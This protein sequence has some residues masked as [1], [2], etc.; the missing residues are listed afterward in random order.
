[1]HA[2]LRFNMMLHRN[3]AAL[4]QNEADNSDC[5]WSA[6]YCTS[7]WLLLWC[8]VVAVVVALSCGANTGVFDM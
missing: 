1:M 8:L 6:W 2:L 4:K 3:A 5:D 7:F